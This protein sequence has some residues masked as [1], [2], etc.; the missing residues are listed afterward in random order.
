MTPVA[1]DRLLQHKRQPC[2]RCGDIDSLEIRRN[3]IS[4]G[5]SQY[6]WYCTYCND[7]AAKGGRNIPHDIVRLWYSKGKITTDLDEVPVLNDY[8]GDTCIICGK[9]G[10][11]YHHFAPQAFIDLFGE[12]WINW[13]GAYL[14]IPHHNLWH[15]IVTWYMPGPAAPNPE[16]VER[17]G[18]H[19]VPIR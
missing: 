2:E 3:I 5:V 18:A 17:Y 6:F 10:V 13:P 1:R 15:S 14:C 4:S 11:Q 19:N 16:M 12:D 8:R 9:T 7:R